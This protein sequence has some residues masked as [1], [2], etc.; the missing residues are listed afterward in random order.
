MILSFTIG[1]IVGTLIK[2]LFDTIIE[3]IE[4]SRIDDD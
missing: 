3:I 1:T 4:I 2:S